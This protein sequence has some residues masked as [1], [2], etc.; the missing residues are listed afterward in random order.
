MNIAEEVVKFKS[1][2]GSWRQDVGIIA[3]L[4]LTACASFGMGY[5][6]G[7]DGGKEPVQVFESHESA[8]FQPVSAEELARIDVSGAFVASVSGSR[9]YLPECG[10]VGRINPENRI[11]F[12]SKEEVEAAGYTP[13]ANCF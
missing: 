3:I 10:G 5:M 8:R 6:A 2:E 11:W 9:Y 13:A 1:S 4:V 12:D 7:K